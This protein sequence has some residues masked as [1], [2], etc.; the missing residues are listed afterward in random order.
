MLALIMGKS[1]DMLEKVLDS[2]TNQQEFMGWVERNVHANIHAPRE[3]QRGV[4]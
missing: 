4:S 2:L 1:Q 3:R